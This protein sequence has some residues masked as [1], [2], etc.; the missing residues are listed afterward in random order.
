MNI[1]ELKRLIDLNH[2][3][4][5]KYPQTLVQLIVNLNKF[6]NIHYK[7]DLNYENKVVIDSNMCRGISAKKMHEI[8]L[9]VPFVKHFCEQYNCNYLIDI[10]SGLVS[11]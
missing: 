3:D 1:E 2:Q 6:R 8:K 5:Q 11:M 10:G 9:M 7:N 4:Q